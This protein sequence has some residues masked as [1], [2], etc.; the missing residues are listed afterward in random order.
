MSVT[1]EFGNEKDIDNVI[2]APFTDHQ[3]DAELLKDTKT[4]DDEL[5]NAIGYKQVCVANLR[6]PQFE[7]NIECRSLGGSLRDGQLY[8]TRSLLWEFWAPFPQPTW[9]LYLLEAQQQQYGHGLR[10]LSYQ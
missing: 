3:H 10:G 1:P 6:I 4:D 2:S 8:R 9:Y 7:L 5:L